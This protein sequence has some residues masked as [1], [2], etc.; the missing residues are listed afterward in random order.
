LKGIFVFETTHEYTLQNRIAI[1]QFGGKIINSHTFKVNNCQI[2]DYAIGEDLVI[3]HENNTLNLP[4]YNIK[5]IRQTDGL[6]I[7]RNGN[8]CP[9]CRGLSSVVFEDTEAHCNSCHQTWNP[10]EMQ[11]CHYKL[12]SDKA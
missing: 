5:E 8:M 2:S 9:A 3:V 7:L 11:F 12:K 10:Q 1:E 4:Y 6:I